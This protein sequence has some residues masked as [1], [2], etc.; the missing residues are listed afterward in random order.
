MTQIC[1]EMTY[2]DHEQMRIQVPVPI[3]TSNKGHL[4]PPRVTRLSGAMGGCMSAGSFPSVL[5]MDLTASPGWLN[6]PV[7][8][9]DCIAPK[10]VPFGLTEEWRHDELPFL[11]MS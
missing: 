4:A 6:R 2:L 1:M 9:L 11:R 10:P 3:S 7:R 5:L 8:S